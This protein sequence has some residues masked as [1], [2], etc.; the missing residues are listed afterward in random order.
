MP[1]G[2]LIAVAVGLGLATAAPAS[3]APR[4]FA[5]PMQST[6]LIK[7]GAA[8]GPSQLADGFRELERRH[9]GYLEFTTVS[10]ELNDPNAV[11]LGPD[12]R[13]AWD[14]ADT[15][16]GLPFYVAIATDESVPD[17]DKAYV[18]LLN[19]HP[20]EPCGQE[21][22]P[23]FI[24]DLLRWRSE[25]PDRILDD[26]GGVTGQR[27]HMTVRE[28]LRKTKIYFV[29]TSPDDWYAGDSGDADNYNNANFNEN[30]VAFQDG[31][32]F[33]HEP[34]LF[35][36]GYS[37]AS[38][39]EGAAVT[40]YLSRIRR[41]ELGGKA[42]AV[43]NDQHG[44]LP[45]SGA[46][47]FMDQGSDPAKLDRLEDYARRLEE[48]MEEVFAKYFTGTG[49]TASQELARE[50]GT[51]RDLLLRKYTELSGQP[52][53]EKALFLTLEW[54]EYATAWEHLDY[55][56]ASSW[57]GWAGSNAGLDADSISFETACDAQSGVYDP[58]LFQ[59]FV[60]N[61]RAANETGVVY[62][63]Q[64]AGKPT[65]PAV[66]K[67]GL[68]GRVGYVETGARVT[69][70]DGN[71]SPPPAGYPGH[72]LIPQIV[73]AP[74]D[75]A[76]SDYFR[77]LQPI[78]STPIVP[79][80]ASDLARRTRDL[81]TLV[82][83]DTDDVDA[84]AIR[85][86]AERGGNVVLTD[87]A[88]RLLPRLAKIEDGA[89]GRRS[90]Y[91]GFSDLD[92]AHP[93][94][95]GL[96]KRARQTYDPVGIGL[97]LLMERDQY[98]PCNPACDASPTTNSAPVWSVAR[99]AFEAAGGRTIGTADVTEQADGKAPGEG[100]ATDRTTIGTLKVGDGRI[101]AF[102][103]LLPTPSEA[104]AHWFGL[105]AY[106]LSIP[107]QRLL[108]RALRWD[109]GAAT[110]APKP[111]ASR[112]RIVVSLPRTVR[113]RR[114]MRGRV[115]VDGRRARV[116]RVG[117]RLVALV[118]LR[119]SGRRTAV[120]RVTAITRSGRTRTTVRRFRTCVATRR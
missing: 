25:D 81:D 38:Q 64:R 106:T 58:A 10:A 34:T 92:R 15:K 86:F 12:G 115:T 72:P 67:H 99:D 3:A 85:A 6:A 78:V 24:E 104:S 66:T 111:C 59:L 110:R 63:A 14:E 60:D 120:V 53:S 90:A 61:V 118:D 71:P 69:D 79:V 17:R 83:S 7:H 108:L 8:T 36:R 65:P 52:V 102:G 57:G 89:I 40:T 87:G 114:V 95:A 18:L 5:E 76:S 68:G 49:T 75:V 37:T 96:Y 107:A 27:H 33:P 50:A 31:W 88:L 91:V 73:Q 13:P 93:W 11:S 22:D 113:G 20:A 70:R 42:F 109:D 26:A 35:D 62:A 51:V 41:D 80:R 46:L 84:A 55:T 103:A 16:D 116:R 98:W 45:T 74:Y 105:D 30:R 112:R 9:P 32:V 54:A 28:V 97:P 44:P 43:A 117:G 21:G 100:T 4:V 23:R 77:D 19:A 119:S 1:R 29:S 2:L 82:V 47:I 48:N 101:V 94:T 56:V 39:P